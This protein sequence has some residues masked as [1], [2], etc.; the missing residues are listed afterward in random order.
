M[1]WNAE[2]KKKI[3]EKFQRKAGDVGSPE[4]QIALVTKRIENLAEHFKSNKKD[5]HSMV[6]MMRLISTRK[7]LLAYLKKENVE[8]YKETISALGLRK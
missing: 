4:V 5:N 6:G 2:E 8:K 7:S 1:E 3:V